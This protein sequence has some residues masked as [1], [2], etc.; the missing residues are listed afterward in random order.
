MSP[1]ALECLVVGCL[2]TIPSAHVGSP[3]AHRGALVDGS[4]CKIFVRTAFVRTHIS[5]VGFISDM[6][7]SKVGHKRSWI[8]WIFVPSYS[9]QQYV[10]GAVASLTK[11][12]PTLPGAIRQTASVVFSR[13]K[14]KTGVFEV[15]SMHKENR[16]LPKA[17]LCK[18]NVNNEVN[19]NRVDAMGVALDLAVQ[20]PYDTLRGPLPV[21]TRTDLIAVDK[22]A[23]E[24]RCC[25]PSVKSRAMCILQGPVYILGHRGQDKDYSAPLKMRVKVHVVQSG[26]CAKRHETAI[27]A[28]HERHR[29]QASYFFQGSCRYLR[30]DAICVT[31]S[32][33]SRRSWILSW[34]YNEQSVGH[35][36]GCKTLRFLDHFLCLVSNARKLEISILRPPSHDLFV[37]VLLRLKL[38]VLNNSSVSLLIAVQTTRLKNSPPHSFNTNL[39]TTSPSLKTKSLGLMPCK[40]SISKNTLR[41]CFLFSKNLLISGP[42]S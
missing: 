19:R 35:A 13:F 39:R 11:V 12:L 17:Y 4:I 23:T 27:G 24:I 25:C 41:N 28:L 15:Q 16:R 33:E 36:S 1:A 32:G 14:S 22:Q 38:K 5:R 42:H 30:Q 20:D 7:R 3:V 29:D 37:P 2:E 6:R 40:A 9:V 34:Q 10:F 26:H 8:E 18:S 31:Q 21:Y